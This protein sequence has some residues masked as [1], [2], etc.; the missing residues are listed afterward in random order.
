MFSGFNV[1]PAMARALKKTIN[2]FDII[3]LHSWRHFQDIAVHYYSKK[4]GVPYI[5]QA[6]G[7]LPRIMTKQMLK[8]IYDVSFGNRLLRDASKVI[9]L[10]QLEA[11]QY[12]GMGV[13]E[14]KI[15]IVPNGIDLSEYAVLPPKGCFKRKFG[16]GDDEKIMLYV[17]RLH[18]SKGLDLLARA[19]KIVS[20][21]VN[22]VRLVVVGPDDGYATAFSRLISSLG[23]EEKVL[24]TGFVEKKGKLA[25]FVDSDVF[26]TP[27]FYG[28]PVTFLEA[29]L[30]G[31]PIITASD[32]LD[33]INNNVGYVTEY[34]SDALAKAVATV[35]HDEQVNRT[36]RN[37]CRHIIKNFDISTVTR[38]VEKVY[39]EVGINS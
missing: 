6:H 32:E 38:Q 14:E 36:F 20:K 22:N 18:E 17:G 15:A 16:I 29:C 1:S 30:A 34:S 10:S 19:F 8:W 13:P 2:E 12:R 35:L 33:W 37:N 9:A 7:S 5:L 26:V 23:I 11:Q 27:R 21:G 4:Y 24:F 28:F 3:H 25:A 31:C 39:E